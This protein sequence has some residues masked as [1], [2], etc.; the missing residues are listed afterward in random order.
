MAAVAQNRHARLLMPM[1]MLMPMYKREVCLAAAA[2]HLTTLDAQMRSDLTY[3][4]TRP[5]L[6][7]LVLGFVVCVALLALQVRIAINSCCRW[8]DALTCRKHPEPL[9]LAL[10]LPE[11][12]CGSPWRA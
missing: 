8:L 10:C 2:K 1:P 9:L 7:R 12:L 3:R 5:A 11:C 4:P 6:G